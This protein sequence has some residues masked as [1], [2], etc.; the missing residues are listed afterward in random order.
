MLVTRSLT[1]GDGR[2][3][4][5]AADDVPAPPAVSFA[6][7]IATLNSM[8]DDTSEHWANDSKLRIK[9]IAV[10][11]AYWKDIYTSKANI[12][13]KP[14]QWKGIKGNWFNWKV[15]SLSQFCDSS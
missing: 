10:A 11:I 2:Q 1:L 13:W 6:H 14:R 8:W 5:F 15:R 12:N 3:L 9:G 7:D 4:I